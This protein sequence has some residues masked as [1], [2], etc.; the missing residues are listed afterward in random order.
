M[1]AN[2]IVALYQGIIQ[3]PKLLQRGLEIFENLISTKATFLADSC[4]VYAAGSLDDRFRVH[5]GVFIHKLIQHFW[6]NP[7]VEKQKSVWLEKKA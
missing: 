7:H 3:D 4:K 2:E 1:D 6:E 5:M